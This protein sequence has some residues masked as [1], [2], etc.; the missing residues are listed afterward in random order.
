M[1]VDVVKTLVRKYNNRDMIPQTLQDLIDQT[2]DRSIEARIRTL[3]DQ[4]DLGDYMQGLLKAI[5]AI[6]CELNQ[7][8]LDD[9][10]FVD[11]CQA[12]DVDRVVDLKDRTSLQFQDLPDRFVGILTQALRD[13]RALKLLRCVDGEEERTF[14]SEALGT[15]PMFASTYHNPDLDMARK[16]LDEGA[17]I[18]DGDNFYKKLLNRDDTKVFFEQG[19]PPADTFYQ[20]LTGS[21]DAFE[22]V[23]EAY[24]PNRPTATRGLNRLIALSGTKLD[25]IERI[26]ELEERND[27]FE[28]DWHYTPARGSTEK[29]CSPLGLIAGYAHR[30]QD[31]RIMPRESLDDLREYG[32]MSKLVEMGADP[33]ED[34]SAMVEAIRTGDHRAVQQLIDY[35]FKPEGHAEAGAAILAPEVKRRKLKFKTLLENGL[36]PADEPDAYLQGLQPDQYEQA[37]SGEEHLY[38]IKRLAQENIDFNRQPGRDALHQWL[39]LCQGSNSRAFVVDQII[40]AQKQRGQFRPPNRQLVRGL[41]NEPV[42]SVIEKHLNGRQLKSLQAG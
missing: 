19:N 5:Q 18:P 42:F 17:Q 39:R 32:V 38:C 9:L 1:I 2:D 31:E 35:G 16:L 30:E 26:Q 13:K 15:S 21:D 11:A 27:D 40:R 10:R 12:Q 37:P 8:T 29:S 36:Q 33:N 25:K 28:M 24:T 22:K 23:V 41:E 4:D 14:I 34:P 20:A 7:L 3:L 6:D